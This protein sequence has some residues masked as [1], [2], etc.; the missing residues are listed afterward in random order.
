M[1][2]QPGGARPGRRPALRPTSTIVLAGGFITAANLAGVGDRYALGQVR[3]LL[4]E[5][6]VPATDGRT[7]FN[8]ARQERSVV[9]AWTPQRPAHDLITGSAW[10][11]GA[12]AA[13]FI[14]LA[15]LMV[16]NTRRA[17]RDLMEVHRAQGQFLA[18]M[19]HE[20]RTPLNGVNALAQSLAESGLDPRRRQMAET[21]HGS[22]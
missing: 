15:I 18:N 21:I 1:D 19:S 11:M 7:A 13:A 8:S 22:G 20:I 10:Q 17:A 4:D 3:L 14:G 9:L 2:G 12:V 16:R 5:R 6:D